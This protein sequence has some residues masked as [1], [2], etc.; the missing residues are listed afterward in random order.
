MLEENLP[1]KMCHADLKVA[2][3]TI[4]KFGSDYRRKQWTIAGGRL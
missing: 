3:E 4:S 2:I 1:G